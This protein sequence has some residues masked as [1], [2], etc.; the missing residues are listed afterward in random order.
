[1][2]LF[3]LLKKVERNS[4]KFS[5]RYMIQ[6]VTNEGLKVVS[7]ITMGAV[8]P[9]KT[10]NALLPYIKKVDGKFP[11]GFYNIVIAEKLN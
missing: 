10:P 7:S 3:G 9:N 6:L 2:F 11:L 5:L 1:M 4:L 8:L